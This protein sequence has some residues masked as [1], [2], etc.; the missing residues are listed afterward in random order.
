MP[1]T[2][3]AKYAPAPITEVANLR[4]DADKVSQ[5]QQVL[6]DNIHLVTQTPGCHGARLLS[7]VESPGWFILLIG[8]DSVEAHEGFRASERFSQWRAAISPFFA[9]DPVIEHFSDFAFAPAP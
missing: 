6:K 9:A 5:F 2:D 7:G 3:F 4:T 8:W 1:M